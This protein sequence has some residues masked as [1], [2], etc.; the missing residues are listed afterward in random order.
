MRERTLLAQP[1]DL[2][3]LELSG[4]PVEIAREVT[5]GIAY[6]YVPYS[7]SATGVLVYQ[8]K[9]PLETQLVW[10]DKRGKELGR[11]GSPGVISEPVLSPDEK[12]VA[13]PRRDI[14]IKR[15]I[16]LLD[17]ARG[18]TSRLTSSKEDNTSPVWSPDGTSIVFE[19]RD[20]GRPANL[21]KKS[22]SEAGDEQRLLSTEQ[23][24]FTEDWSRDGRYIL[25]SNFDPATYW[26]LWVLPTF[27]DRQPMPFLKGQ[28]N[29]RQ[30][31]FSPDGS[32][33]AYS[34]DESGK[35]EVY[36][37]SFPATGF[38]LQVSNGGGDSR[39]SHDGKE[40]FYIALDKKL[41][42]VELKTV[43]G[44]LIAGVPRILF[45]T[46]VVPLRDMRNHYDVSSDGRF[47]FAK[48]VQKA[49]DATIN[50]VVN[51]AADLKR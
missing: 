20:V 30:A 49:S 17:L 24:K 50:V 39:W 6:N 19:K 12:F 22:T 16:W 23:I 34:S 35:N 41:M 46:D 1:F 31:L 32:W 2:V 37:R 42:S 25:Y 5:T 13:F 4:Q 21:Y 43:S 48:P 47:L 15:D 3:S 10:L 14:Q 18:A 33:I 40:L 29:E 44:K 26:D 51:W 11:V 27:A 38:K 9:S 7:V 45:E 36:V 8:S 28:F